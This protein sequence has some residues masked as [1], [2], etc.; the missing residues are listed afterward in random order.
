MDQPTK[1]DCYILAFKFM[2][3]QLLSAFIL[4]NFKDIFDILDCAI[5]RDQYNPTY[6]MLSYKY[7]ILPKRNL[8][9]TTII[10]NNKNMIALILALFLAMCL[11]LII[12]G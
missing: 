6:F 4:D 7:G 9:A 11:R 2:T 10:K 3:I 8:P 5:Q 12:V 1:K